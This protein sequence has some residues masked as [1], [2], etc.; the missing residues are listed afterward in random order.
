MH[1]T[2]VKEKISQQQAS[3]SIYHEFLTRIC[4][5]H[6]G[7]KIEFFRTDEKADL[8]QRVYN[9]R[10][11]GYNISYFLSFILFSQLFIGLSLRL[12]V[13]LNAPVTLFIVVLLS[14]LTM[15]LSNWVVMYFISIAVSFVLCFCNTHDLLA[16]VAFGHAPALYYFNTFFPC[17][18]LLIASSC[19]SC[20][21]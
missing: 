20:D 6:L 15:C 13:M 17:M 4:T 8:S 3:Q 21:Q 18:V 12:R 14:V 16:Y 19:L 7:N 5:I 2:E 10:H 1:Q 9:Q 11:I